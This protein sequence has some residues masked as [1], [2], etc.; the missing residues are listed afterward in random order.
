M[1]K[2]DEHK[3]P[4][5]DSHAYK[6]ATRDLRTVRDW[7]EACSGEDFRLNGCACTPEVECYLHAHGIPEALKALERLEAD[8]G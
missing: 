3:Q 6:G 8:R 5:S 1:S 4:E 7:L 2:T